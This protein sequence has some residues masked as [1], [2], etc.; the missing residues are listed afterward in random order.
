[1]TLEKQI[2]FRTK[3]P[4]QLE[5]AR[6]WIDNE[7][8]E[9]LYGGA[10]Y[11]GKSYFGC[12]MI[13][14]DAL[15]YPETNYFIARE[16]L[17]DL[18]KYTIPSIHEVF[19]HWGLDIN[20]YASYNGQDNVYKLTNG[21]LVYLIACKEQPSD[22]L[23]EGFGSMQMTRGW[24]EEG[25]EVA[26]A[27]KRN[28]ALAV[29]RWNNE[30]YGLK[31]KLLI[32]CNPKKGWMKRQ[33]IEPWKEGK[34]PK[35]K[36]F[37]PAFATDNK[38]GDK[39]YIKG[40]S[41]E[42]DKVTRQRLWLGDWD[43]D[44]DGDS[45]VSYDNLSDA[46]SNTIVK[47]NQ[48]YL[49]VD[50]AR[51]G[52]DSIVY[53]FWNGLELNRIE[54]YQKQTTDKTEQQIK[55]FAAKEQIPW[56]HIAVDEGGVG[57]GVVDHLTGVKGF[58][59]NA[60]PMPTA[61]EIR[62]KSYMPSIIPQDL[63]PKRN[64]FNFKSQCGFKLAE[65]INEHGIAFRVPEYRDEIIGDLSSLLRQKDFDKDKKLQLKPKEEVRQELGKSPDIGDMIVMR[66]FFEVM[67]NASNQDPVEEKRLKDV[68]DK[69]FRQVEERQH[70]N[71][72]K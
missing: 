34:L 1:M 5:A 4:K 50:V 53:G 27:A 24:I 49:I 7:T 29:G 48:K 58:I 12:S 13:F 8:E 63:M 6:Y 18:R 2:E 54:L 19:K 39:D 70:L 67:K 43:Y 15:I 66:M 44:D 21:S 25:G 55:D 68:I 33:F 38:H 69:Q 51:L 60:S 26:E 3:N 28:L 57:G 62:I 11:G 59:S 14:G 23:Y 65:L 22:P 41:E 9:L 16:E 71:S 72:S 47:D 45:L 61:N 46:F 64:F 37:V 30:K 52:K 40:L 31:K 32:T 17:T 35:S 42:K 10:K 36:K 20:D 56:S